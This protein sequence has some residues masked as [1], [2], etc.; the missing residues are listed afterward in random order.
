[1]INTVLLL[2]LDMSTNWMVA[3]GPVEAIAPTQAAFT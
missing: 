2:N 1:M 3:T